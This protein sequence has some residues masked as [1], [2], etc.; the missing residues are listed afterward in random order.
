[1]SVSGHLDVDKGRR[2]T[3]KGIERLLRSVHYQ[4]HGET[5]KVGVKKMSGDDWL[6]IRCCCEEL[7]QR[8]AEALKSA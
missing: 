3:A 1:M 6:D 8:A 2:E 5:P 7:E 4:S